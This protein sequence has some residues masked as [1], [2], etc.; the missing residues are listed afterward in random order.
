MP[1]VSSYT[2]PLASVTRNTRAF[3]WRPIHDRCFE[4]IKVL[5][6]RAP[7]L[8]PIDPKS[9]D[10]IWLIC[11]ASLSGVG[12]LLGQGPEW[13]NCRPAGF[14]SRKFTTAQ[15]AYRVFEME[16]IAILEALAKWEDKLLGH[17][18]VD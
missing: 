12:A 16:T 2:G 8:K 3:E 6:C 5:A 9:P 7:I 1:D 18:L 15:R 17:P 14:M 11:D 13:H 10:P 4:M